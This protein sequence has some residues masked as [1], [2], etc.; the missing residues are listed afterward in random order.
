MKKTNAWQR[1]F[2]SRQGFLELYLELFS[3]NTTIHTWLAMHRLDIAVGV[4]TVLNC[5]SLKIDCVL[6]TS[7]V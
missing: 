3:N 1:F 7:R 4:S 5:C 6:R 2:S